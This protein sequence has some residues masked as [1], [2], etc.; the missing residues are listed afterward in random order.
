M[1]G[2]GV[3]RRDGGREV[4]RLTYALSLSHE[5][6]WGRRMPIKKKLFA[7][8]L[9]YIRGDGTARSHRGGGHAKR[10]GEKVDQPRAG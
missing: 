1:F 7:Q 3:G 2:F 6:S 4:A 10:E 5:G 9:S 8:L